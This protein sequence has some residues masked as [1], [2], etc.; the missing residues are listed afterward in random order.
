MLGTIKSVEFPTYDE[1]SE[2]FKINILDS[3]NSEVISNQKTT[4]FKWMNGDVENKIVVNCEGSDLNVS[5]YLYKIFVPWVK[6]NTIIKPRQVKIEQV[7]EDR[8]FNEGGEFEKTMY[9]KYSDLSEEEKGKYLEDENGYAYEEAEPHVY[10][11]TGAEFEYNNEDEDPYEPAP[12]DLP[13]EYEGKPFYQT[14]YIVSSYDS[15]KEVQVGG[16]GYIE[17]KENE[18][19]DFRDLFN[20]TLRIGIYT[21]GRAGNYDEINYN[22]ESLDNQILPTRWYNRQEPFEVEFVVNTNTGMQ[23]IFNNLVLI[24]NNV[25]PNEIEY[26]I[27]GDAYDFNKVGIF[28][29]ENFVELQYDDDLRPKFGKYYTRLLTEE[30]NNTKNSQDLE[31]TIG[32][33]KFATKF[34][35]EVC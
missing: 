8:T 13:I 24:S 35:T 22:D 9:V 5:L 11:T 16:E 15:I 12:E 25:Q 1:E 33:G 28:A 34:K 21:H 20:K 10:K 3:R 19:K 26:E 31:F 14:L 4:V 17:E 29:K 27:V 18:T 32:K 23:K 2:Q 30:F 7:D 6:I